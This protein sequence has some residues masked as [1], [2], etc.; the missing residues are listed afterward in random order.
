MKFVFPPWFLYLVIYLYQYRLTDISLS[1]SAVLCYLTCCSGFPGGAEVKVSACNVGDLGSIPGSG[2][3]PGEGNGNS[4]QYSCLENPI[5][6]GA[7][8]ATVHGSQR[9]RH[10]W[11]TSLSLSLIAQ[12]AP[13]LATGSPF[14]C[15]CVPLTN[16]HNFGSLAL[17]YFLAQ[18][19][20]PDSSCMFQDTALDSAI[21]PSSSCHFY[22][23][24][25]F[26]NQDL[27]W[28]CSML[29]ECCWV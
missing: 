6:G 18:G 15:F 24:R 22:W 12:I 7:W 19:D 11:G 8:W 23:K 26:K 10:D 21:S 25:V 4:L 27:G 13:T 14:C 16:S 3:S 20:V 1:Y 9:V 5:D 17:P 2:R 29:L 28:L